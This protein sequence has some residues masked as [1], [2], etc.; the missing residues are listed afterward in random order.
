MRSTSIAGAG[1]K[2]EQGGRARPAEVL[3]VGRG[4]GWWACATTLTFSCT[5][6]ILFGGFRNSI[7]LGLLAK[8]KCS[9]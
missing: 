4:S 7:L 3:A 1:P 2:Q 6:Q 8:I 9:I 5:V